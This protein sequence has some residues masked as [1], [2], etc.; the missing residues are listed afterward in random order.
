MAKIGILGGTF[1]PIHKGHI[2]MAKAA[3]AKMGL[4]QIW[5]IP[6]GMPP[7]KNA[8]QQISS[9][10]R[11]T[12]CELAV[13]ELEYIQVKDFEQHCLLPNYS[14]K[15]LRYVSEQFPEHTFYFILGEDS[16]RYFHEWVHPEV[17]SHYAN[18]VVISRNALTTT[19]PEGS[20]SYTTPLDRLI[21]KSNERFPGS[22]Y[23]VNMEP[24]DIS[25]TEIRD[26]IYAGNTTSYLDESVAQYIM[27][28]HLYQKLENLPDMKDIMKDIKEHVKPSRYFHIL[29]VMD[30]AA[31]LAM[32]YSYP[33]EYARMAGLLHD[34]A[35]YLSGEEQLKYCKKYNMEVS[36]A[37]RLAPQ[38]LHAKTGAHMAKYRYHVQQDE[39]LHAIEV[40]TTGCPNMSLLDKILFIADYIEPSRD[41][42]PRLKELRHLAYV[43]LDVTVTFILHDT[44]YYLKEK[45]QTMDET[46]LT[47][48]RYYKE[49]LR[50]K[51]KDLTLREEE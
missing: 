18:I 14:Y 23:K 31:N 4:D 5:I 16:L 30:T 12:M 19:V 38:L 44:I 6:S 36:D 15:T 29:G 10:D 27:D 17:I 48:Y 21:E 2:A 3:K 39:I 9:Y 22:F 11:Y 45:K 46:T 50:Q 28:H 24:V 42:A 20:I 40:H 13:R 51:G 1:N 43:D 37:E 41:K 49:Q 8:S 7:H 35:K 32:R 33:V 47:T 25:S 26:I 34:C